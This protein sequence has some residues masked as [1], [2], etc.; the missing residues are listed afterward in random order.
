MDLP[1][2]YEL[3]SGS[4]PPFPR[5]PHFICLYPLSLSSSSPWGNASSCAV[6]AV[7]DTP[8]AGVLRCPHGAG[9]HAEGEDGSPDLCLSSS[10]GCQITTASTQS[11]SKG[12][13]Q[14]LEHPKLTPGLGNLVK[15][16]SQQGPPYPPGIQ[17][18]GLVPQPPS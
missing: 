12:P 8:K 18:T 15:P 7:T 4:S 1:L 13:C 9:P 16:G 5:T 2:A 3:H 17:P 11:L 10:P 14:L 6:G